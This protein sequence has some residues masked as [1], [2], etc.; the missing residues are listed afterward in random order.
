MVGI[1]EAKMIREGRAAAIKVRN[2]NRDVYIPITTALRRF[3]WAG[4]AL[5]H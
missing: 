1:M 2:I 5:R 3:P 4:R